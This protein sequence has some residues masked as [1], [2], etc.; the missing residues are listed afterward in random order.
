MGTS[1]CPVVSGV[2]LFSHYLMSSSFLNPGLLLA[3]RFLI[4][5]PP[6]KPVL[7]CICIIFFIKHLLSLCL[8]SH[9]DLYY[10]VFKNNFL[11]VWMMY[12]ELYVFNVWTSWVLRWVYICET[13]M[14][15]FVINISPPND[16]SCPEKSYVLEYKICQF[17]ALWVGGIQGHMSA[18]LLTGW[19]PNLIPSL[20]SATITIF[21]SVALTYVSSVLPT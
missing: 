3:V 12:K 16:S 5:A 4:T 14:P 20:P 9:I 7:W 10:F 6:G 2:V 1:W 17:F 11:H 18:L 21:L 13:V 19:S 15:I 8:K